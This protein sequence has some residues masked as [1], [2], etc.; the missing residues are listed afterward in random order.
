VPAQKTNWVVLVKRAVLASL[1]IGLGDYILLEVG[2]PLGAFLFAFGLYGVCMLGANL[3]T[4]KCGFVISDKK[5]LEL[6]AI[7]IVNLVAG[8]ALGWIFSQADASLIA[9]ANEKIAKWD[10]SLDFFIRSALCG[11]IMY[12]AVKCYK[13]GSAWGIFFGV[14]LFILAGFQHSIANV[15]TA[16]IATYFD[17]TILLCAGGNFV[18]SVVTAWLVGEAEK[19]ITAKAKKK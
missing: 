10:F 4:G 9:A 13:L 2:T 1:L 5:W 18:G 3:F 8:W 17:W 15:I 11:A 6:G 12:L 7:L 19:T 14:P 16:G